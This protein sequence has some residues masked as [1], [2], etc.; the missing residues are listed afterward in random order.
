MIMIRRAFLLVLLAL[1]TGCSWLGGWF[2]S[3]DN[4][5]RP[6]EL[7]T[8]V[9]PVNVS[10]LW[11]TKVGSGT[12]GQFIRLTPTL[13]DGR[14]YA[15]SHDGTILALDALTG[16]RLWDVNSDLP[17]SGGV[18]LSDSGLVPVS[19]THLDVYK[20]QQL[21]LPEDQAIAYLQAAMQDGQP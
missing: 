15:A 9:S 13:A 18:G 4:S 21:T 11:E 1:S 5:L 19:Y 2:G 6:A 16:Q 10:Q 8:I 17:I 20:R 7:K 12:A 14:L 3:S